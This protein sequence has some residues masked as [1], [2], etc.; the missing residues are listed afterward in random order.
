MTAQLEMTK[1]RR[2]EILIDYIETSSTA[3]AVLRR[4]G[5]DNEDAKWRVAEVLRSQ[6]IQQPEDFPCSDACIKYGKA[7]AEYILDK[8]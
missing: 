2:D 6:Q 4:A 8:M 5:F 7:I 1:E 3:L